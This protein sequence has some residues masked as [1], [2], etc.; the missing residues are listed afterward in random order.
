[1]AEEKPKVL[2][3]C[4]GQWD[5]L[6]PESKR[7]LEAFAERLCKA[8]P[9]AERDWP[10]DAPH[11]NG[12]YSCRCVSCLLTFTGHKRRVLCR[13]CSGPPPKEEPNA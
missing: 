3:I 4:G 5:D 13:A 6:P 12:K 11:E 7:E 1:M 2:T 8:P 10:E 9:R